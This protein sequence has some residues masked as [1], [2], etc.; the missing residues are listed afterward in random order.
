MAAQREAAICLRENL[1]MIRASVIYG[2]PSMNEAYLDAT[3]GSSPAIVQD[4]REIEVRDARPIV[5]DLSLDREG[6]TLVHHAAQTPFNEDFLALNAVRQD[7][8]PAANRRYVAEM[9]RAVGS[10]VTAREVIPQTRRVMVR[11]TARAGRTTPDPIASLVH[12]DYSEELA[13]QVVSDSC[14]ALGRAVP[15]YNH[16]AIFQTWRMLS[17][18]PQD[19]TLAICDASTVRIED[20]IIMRAR[21]SGNEEKSVRLCRYH[22]DQRWFYF[23]DMRPEEFL[24][25]KG[26]DTAAPNS[27]TGAHVAIPLPESGETNARVSLE[28]RF[29]AFY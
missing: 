28:A 23:K 8:S 4:Q 13:Q 21:S 24:L 9:Q 10:V 14:A 12:L 19:N 7:D 20:S 16:M 29:I 5:D 17:T 22:P 6:F 15:A 18:P 26:F 11:A 25:F 27:M 2:D 3:W 1:P